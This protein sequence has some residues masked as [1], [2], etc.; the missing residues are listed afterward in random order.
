MGSLVQTRLIQYR[1][2][3]VAQFLLILFCFFVGR[4]CQFVIFI[5]IFIVLIGNE[6]INKTILFWSQIWS[7]KSKI[8][9]KWIAICYF[10]NVERIKIVFCARWKRKKME[11]M[12]DRCTNTSEFQSIIVT[13]RFF[14]AERDCST[15]GVS[16]A[17]FTRWTG[18][19]L[20]HL[21]RIVTVFFNKLIRFAVQRQI[22][23][24]SIST[25]GI[26]TYLLLLLQCIVQICV[27]DR[28]KCFFFLFHFFFFFFWVA[29]Q[30]LNTCSFR[31]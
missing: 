17:R 7:I 16:C 24:S 1:F 29:H 11:T 14:A 13:C 28:G 15:C 3:L 6:K 12:Q 21:L 22:K 20:L 31:T 30:N 25:N 27:T 5:Q 18:S 10:H 8:R 23:G 4:C 26:Q 2:A 9:N 19:M